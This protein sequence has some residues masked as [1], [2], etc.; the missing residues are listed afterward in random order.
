[1]PKRNYKRILIFLC[2]L[3]AVFSA[4][5][6]EKPGEGKLA[7]S[8]FLTAEPVIAALETYKNEQGKYPQA[9]GELVPRYL[10]SDPQKDENSEIRFTYYPVEENSS[11]SL[12]LSYPAFFGTDD[13]SYTPKEKRWVCG[14]KM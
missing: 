14:G 8:G 5:C 2:L 10:E 12:R 11:Y 1:M 3:A 7:R 6:I 9:L 4:G 13:C